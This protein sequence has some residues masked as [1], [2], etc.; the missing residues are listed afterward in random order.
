MK[1]NVIEVI[2]ES[3]N[4]IFVKV[5]DKKTLLLSDEKKQI[6]ASE[7]YKCLN[8]KKDKQYSLNELKEYEDINED[9]KNY[10]KEIYEIF[11]TIIKNI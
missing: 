4:K 2:Y 10:L 8:Y 6:N 9:Y 7:I 3:K 5:E 11:K 1:I